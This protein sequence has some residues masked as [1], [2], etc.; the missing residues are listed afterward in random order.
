MK[1][2]V[3][4]ICLTVSDTPP[5][6]LKDVSFSLSGGEILAVVGP[7]GAGKTTLLNALAGFLP[8][9]HGAIILDNQTV[10]C[11]TYNVSPNKR[12]VGYIFQEHNLL[13]HL[14][15]FENL[16]LGMDTSQIKMQDEEI[17]SLMK[18][19]HIHTIQ[20]HYP[21]GVSGGQQ[22]RVALGRALLH[23]KKLLLFDEPFSGLDKQ[24]MA[25][26]ASN[27]RESVKK[28]KRIA[29][30]VT[31]QMD[32]AFLIAD[33]VAILDEGVLLQVDSIV[34]IYQRPKSLFIAK[35]LGPTNIISATVKSKTRA[36]T[37]FGEVQFHS[38]QTVVGSDKVLL[39]TRPDDWRI[40]KDVNGT[41]TVRKIMFMGMQYMITVSETKNQY[42][43]LANHDA[44]FN[45]GD[46]VAI[47]LT[48]NH[49]YR[50]YNR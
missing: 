47:S 42:Q 11:A 23:N 33:K 13:E 38:T 14:T 32:E 10:S 19:L 4:N 41:G 45:L 31:H 44:D 21:S 29:L 16:T 40:V 6:S 9:E 46:K 50:Q 36:M 26:L 28:Y 37:K 22:Q 1:C 12:N 35:L 43:I 7:S 17:Q 49:P 5:F 30:L 8:I 25:T 18:E 2:I 27:I 3:R 24:R 34:D 48:K 39:L 20:Q 15:L